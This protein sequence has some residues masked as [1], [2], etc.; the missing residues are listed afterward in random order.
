MIKEKDLKERYD[1]N[2][3]E[4]SIFINI[5][6]ENNL[7]DIYNEILKRNYDKGYSIG[8][9]KGACDGISGGDC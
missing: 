5:L 1:F 4:F 8:Y 7:T 6:E 2:Q 3:T 9:D